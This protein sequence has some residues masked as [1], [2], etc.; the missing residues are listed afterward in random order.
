W[1]ERAGSG[2][3][4]V[5]D[6]PVLSTFVKRVERDGLAGKLIL[7]VSHEQSTDSGQ[8]T[9][10][11]MTQLEAEAIVRRADL[12]LNFDYRIDTVLMSCFRRTALVDIDPGLL[13]FW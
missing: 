4:Q 9:Y 5:D 11:G 12:L 7:Y 2:G 8:Y 13:Q 10:I 1:L 6:A 3:G